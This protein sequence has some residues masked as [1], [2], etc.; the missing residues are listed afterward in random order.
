[1]SI[2]LDTSRRRTAGGACV[3]APRSVFVVPIV[4][5]IACNLHVVTGVNQ[6]RSHLGLLIQYSGG[7]E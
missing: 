6:V 2:R 3:V 7:V 1:M 5:G 4:S